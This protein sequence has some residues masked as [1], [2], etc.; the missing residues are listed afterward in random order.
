MKIIG[1]SIAGLNTGGALESG[2]GILDG[3]FVGHC[4][5]LT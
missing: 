1:L 5:P 3:Y 4:F 2:S